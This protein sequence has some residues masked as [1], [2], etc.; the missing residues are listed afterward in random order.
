MTLSIYV[1]VVPSA[2]PPPSPSSSSRS[3]PEIPSLPTVRWLDQDERVNII[4]NYID[5][6]PPPSDTIYS[7]P[8]DYPPSAARIAV[9]TLS[10]VLRF[11]AGSHWPNIPSAEPFLVVKLMGMTKSHTTLGPVALLMLF[12]DL[13]ILQDTFAPTGPQASRLVV[14]LTGKTEAHTRHYIM[15]THT[16]IQMSRLLITSPHL[17]GIC[18]CAMMW[19]FQGCVALP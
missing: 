12:T 13:V 19:M 3:A 9:R 17:C 15:I 8:R 2:A 14:S 10:A 16:S 4:D 18:S 7:L 1:E 6:L 11:H 5:S